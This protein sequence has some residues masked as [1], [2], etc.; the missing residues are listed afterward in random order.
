MLLCAAAVTVPVMSA[1]YMARQDAVENADNELATLAGTMAYRLDQHMFE[2]YREIQNIAALTPLRDLWNSDPAQLRTVFER[3][4]ATMPEYAWLGYANAGG[5]ISASTNGVLEGMPV[6]EHPLFIAGMKG[7]TLRDVH[8]SRR[9]G[10]L[11][12]KE[13]VDAPAR[14]VDIA[15]PVT[16]ASGNRIGV[17]GALMNWTWADNVRRQILRDWHL[18]RSAEIW[19]LDS[20]GGVI[21]GPRDHPGFPDRIAELR[22]DGQLVFTDNGEATPFVTALAATAPVRDYPGLGWVVAARMP[23]HLIHAPANRL[24]SS[25]LV[26]GIGVVLCAS[27][28]AWVL[29]GLVTRPLRHLA[30]R[31]DAIGRDPEIRSVERQHGSA[32]VLR[33]SAAVRS[34]LR[35]IGT[36]EEKRQQQDMLI[37]EM[38]LV[39]E[40]QAQASAASARELAADMDR[41]RAL[42]DYDPL[43]G[44]FNRRAFL[45][46]AEAALEAQAGEPGSPGILMIDADHFKTVNDTFG[47]AAGDE[48]LRC[49][50]NV[51]RQ[52]MGPEGNAARFGGEEFLMLLDGMS[53][54][55]MLDLAETVRR[56]I[57]E[58]SIHWHQD[59]ISIT[60]SIGYAAAETTDRDVEDIIQRADTALYAAKAGGRNRVVSG[61]S[62][63]GILRAA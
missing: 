29:A 15:M 21:L 40:E 19:V 7:A 9:M 52:H 12:Q 48:V 3:L 14:F 24:A 57:S 1:A 43:T 32:D 47:H 38:Q 26:V 16:D 8:D 27:M 60:V 42:A 20:A 50:A 34:L 49:I 44:L 5:I 23:T 28:L 17:L 53:D 18:E 61:R 13:P 45:P 37:A 59:V 51:I 31:L 41:L 39:F 35:R 36:V 62:K 58:L 22:K 2:R 63:D 30:Q 55:A 25:I 6:G 11:V 46:L 56:D 33:L 10:E 54:E 4:Q